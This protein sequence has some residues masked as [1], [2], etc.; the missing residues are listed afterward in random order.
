MVEAAKHAGE[1]VVLFFK[2]REL[3]DL[4]VFSKSDP[5][6]VAHV[7][8]EGQAEWA[9]VG[10]T[11][12]VDNELNPNFQTPVR[13]TYSFEKKQHLRFEVFDDDGGGDKEL[14]GE[15]FT[16]LPELVASTG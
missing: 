16:T 4:D 2:G 14:I 8:E 12:V 11:E 7:K 5:F 9:K 1:E 6:V 15:A 3:A 10:Q 13:L